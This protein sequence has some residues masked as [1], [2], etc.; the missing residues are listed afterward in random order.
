M[1]WNVEL[2]Q[3]PPSLTMSDST[4]YTFITLALETAVFSHPEPDSA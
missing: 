4:L 2:R 1:L 3:E